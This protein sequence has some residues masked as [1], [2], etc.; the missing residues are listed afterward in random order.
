MVVGMKKSGNSFT[1]IELLVVIAII[2]IL[3][4]MLLPALQQARSRAMSAKCVGNL[5]QLGTV[6]AQYMDAHRGFWPA[7]HSSPVNTRTWVYHLYVEGYLGGLPDEGLTTVT[8][9]YNAFKD[10]MKSGKNQ[11]VVCPNTPINQ[12]S[13]AQSGNFYPQCYGTKYNHSPADNPKYEIGK[14]GYFPGSGKYNYGYKPTDPPTRVSDTVSPSQFILLADSAAVVNG[15]ATQ[16]GN[17]TGGGTTQHTDPNYGALYF[18]HNGRINMMAFAGNVVSG[19]PDYV[20][21]N[22]FMYSAMAN[23]DPE[24]RGYTGGISSL[25]G[26]WIIADPSLIWQCYNGE[27]KPY[28]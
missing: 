6:A 2:A 7:S 26:S 9:F 25:P 10:W 5:K 3:A 28:D 15:V 21:D 13:Y 20:K 19:S 22:C 27:T 17:I 1:L 16:R 11:L 4:A 24:R 14:L 12:A 23:K 8:K 18:G